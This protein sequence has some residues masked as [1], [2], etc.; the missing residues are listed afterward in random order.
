MNDRSPGNAEHTVS[1]SD[2][3][4]SA[5]NTQ[6]RRM[7]VEAFRRHMGVETRLG[8]LSQDEQCMTQELLLKKYSSDRWNLQGDVA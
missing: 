7:L 5:N 4:V 1:L 8:C 3:G 6:L 2:C